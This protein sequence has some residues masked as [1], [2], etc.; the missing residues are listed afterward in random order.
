MVNLRISHLETTMSYP[1]PTRNPK[2]SVFASYQVIEFPA[3]FSRSLIAAGVSSAKRNHF[4]Y[5]VTR[6]LLGNV[7]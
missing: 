4:I 6:Y 2:I 3:T 5:S 1:M 7:I